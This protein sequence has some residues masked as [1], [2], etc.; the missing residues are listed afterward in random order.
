MKKPIR[1]LHFDSVLEILK[2][3]DL[4]ST[5]EKVN[6][7]P[8][9]ADL[10][11]EISSYID[12]ESFSRRAVLGIDIYRYG[13][14][15][16]L[17]Q[18]LIPA[19]FKIFFEK[20]IRL[21]LESNQY[22]FQ[23]YDKKAI[24]KA[25]ISTGDGGFLILETPLHAVLFAINF[26]LVVRSYN[27]Y[28]LFPKLRKIIGSIELRYAITHDTLFHFDDNYYGSAIINNARILNKDNLNR[29]LIDE[30]TYTWFL[31]N[32]D[33]I[34][35]L[36]VYTIHDIA[37]VYDFQE[38]ELKWIDKGENLIIPPKKSRYDG[39]INSDISK[40][41]QIQSKEMYL[42][43]Y[44]LHIQVS[45]YIRSDASQDKERLITISLGNLNT[46]GI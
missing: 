38:Y 5:Y 46:S 14:F 20:A 42:N 11:E 30:S 26:E 23:N 36:Q 4:E 19:L 3:Y 41:G 18:T 9:H 13:M 32:C 34:E 27:A 16:H 35:N 24:E 10:Y 39:I 8:N 2:E 21:C 29:C 40:I 7:I 1:K 12:T 22:V 15:K 45:M 37:N 28:H 33:G 31:I 43:I 17:E 25:F 6:I 44:N